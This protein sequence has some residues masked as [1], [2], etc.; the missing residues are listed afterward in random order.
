MIPIT[1][2][3]KVGEEELCAMSWAL[4]LNNRLSKPGTNP[5]DQGP[6]HEEEHVIH[7]WQV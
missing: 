4:L 6:A 2:T 7:S 3:E 1:G 5:R